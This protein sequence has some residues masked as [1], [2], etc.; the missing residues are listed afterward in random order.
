MPAEPRTGGLAGRAA[1]ALEAYRD[2]DS[3]AMSELVDEITP[4]LWHIARHQGLDAAAAEDVVQ[5]TWLRLVE[6][7]SRIEDPRAVL[8][9]LITTTRREAWR[10]ARG[11]RRMLPTEELPEDAALSNPADDPGELL[12]KGQM[13]D[14]VWRHFQRLSER[15]RELLAAVALS[16]PPDYA[17]VSVALGMPVGSI[18][19]TRGRC[20]AKLRASLEADPAWEVTT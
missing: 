3:A 8:K 6:G 12:A 18:G 5:T 19:P 9:W 17:T 20:L 14:V 4:M 16:E 15:C 11:S 13:R 10:V 2:G 1:A 7:A